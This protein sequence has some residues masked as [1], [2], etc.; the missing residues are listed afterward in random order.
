MT[1]PD[2]GAGGRPGLL[3]AL[4]R[5]RWGS[6]RLSRHQDEAHGSPRNVCQLTEWKAPGR[7]G[8]YREIARASPKARRAGATPVPDMDVVLKLINVGRRALRLPLLCAIPEGVPRAPEECPLAKALSA[9]TP[10][11]AP[12]RRSSGSPAWGPRPW[13]PSGGSGEDGGA[14]QGQILRPGHVGLRRDHRRGELRRPGRGRAASY[15][16]TVIAGT[17]ERNASRWKA[18]WRTP[19]GARPAGRSSRSARL[20]ATGNGGLADESR[21]P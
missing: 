7:V 5:R 1:H 6:P 20:P 18:L 10:M 11:K 9:G 21:G 4:A 12:A 3:K 8:W 13:L 15:R 16:S 2:A 17:C 19:V 14:G